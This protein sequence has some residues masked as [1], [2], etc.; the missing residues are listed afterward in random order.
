MSVTREFERK[1]VV[2]QLSK[3]AREEM[4]KW[5]A[6][7]GIKSILPKTKNQKL[8]QRNCNRNAR[9]LESH[10]MRKISHGAASEVRHI[11]PEEI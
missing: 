7:Q 5:K 11:K 8:E 9:R 10:E 6:E 2:H 4:E 1:G 3:A